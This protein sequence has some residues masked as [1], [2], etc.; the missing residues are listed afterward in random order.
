MGPFGPA[1]AHQ[2][3]NSEEAAIKPAA[4]GI[5]FT[6]WPLHAREPAAFGLYFTYWPLHARGAA[7]ASPRSAGDLISALKLR[8]GDLFF[9]AEAG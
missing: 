1:Q 2:T 4:L 6:Y 7:L 8:L 9:F 3:P 5:Y